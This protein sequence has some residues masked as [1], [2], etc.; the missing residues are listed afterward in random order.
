MIGRKTWLAAAAGIALAAMWWQ[1]LASLGKPGAVTTNDGTTFIGDVSEANGKLSVTDDKGSGIEIDKSNVRSTAYFETPQ[2][3][4]NAR[5]GQLAPSDVKGRIA[6]AKWAV[7][8]EQPALA[9]QALD[10]AL[11]IEPNNGEA[12]ALRKSV[13]AAGVAPPPATGPGA[14][15]ATPPGGLAG[16]TRL[17]TK[18]EIN[19]IRQTEWQPDENAVRVVV[20]KETKAAFIARSRDLTPQQFNRM[21][22]T[23]QARV[24]LRDGTDKMRSGVHV[25]TEPATI[26]TYKL[27]VQKAIL[28]GCAAAGCHDAASTTSFVL[29]NEPTDEATFT[30]FLVL[31]NYRTKVK[32]VE[33]LM[34][35]RDHPMDSLL[36]EYSL[37]PKVAATPHPTAPGY[38]GVFR[39]VQDPRYKLIAQ[40]LKS[41][42]TI[43]PDYDVDLTKPPKEDAPA[44][45][46]VPAPEGAA[47]AGAGGTGAP[48]KPA[49]PADP[50]TPAKG[51][52]GAPEGAGGAK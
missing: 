27:N 51:G 6:L 7:K 35:D 3:E 24:I 43:A 40:W 2:D 11:K 39:N 31:Q 23:E 32:G 45:G 20:D 34:V 37:A 17:V 49:G 18:A 36:S 26:Q 44:E 19:R 4:Y 28:K 5:M 15:P 33:R 50:S 48:G 16:K 38:T 47:P 30:N 42:P 1:P 10:A 12:I 8:R 14:A 13:E 52:G 9:K 22:P 25:L 41:M 21:S 29:H 46:D